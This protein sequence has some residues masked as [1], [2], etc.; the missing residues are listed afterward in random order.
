MPTALGLIPTHWRAG[1]MLDPILGE[2]HPR[3]ITSQLLTLGQRSGS[4]IRRCLIF[5]VIATVHVS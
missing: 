3:D 5:L 2:R 1:R 4:R